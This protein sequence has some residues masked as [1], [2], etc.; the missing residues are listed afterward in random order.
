MLDAAGGAHTQP[1]GGPM[2]ARVATYSGDANALVR[3]FEA[4]RG[5][6]E[7]MDGFS[8]AYFCVDRATGKALTMTLWDSEQALE[9]SAERAH[10]L[11]SQATQPSGA[12]TDS[13]MQ[14][15]VVMTVQKAG[16]TTV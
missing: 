2:F 1:K 14:Y 13:V 10:Q 7:Q 5:D 11:R 6:L 9:A 15:E 16:A 4:A 3:G 8:N 12:T